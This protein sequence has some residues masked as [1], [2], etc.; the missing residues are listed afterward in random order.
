MNDKNKLTSSAPLFSGMV[1]LFFI[2]GFITILNDLL[3]PV[4]K[5]RLGL[6][7]AESMLVQFCFFFTYFI[8]SLPMAWLVNKL[9]YKKSMIL[10]LM[11]IA[12]GCLVFIPADLELVYGVFLFGLF[13]L[14][15]GVVMLQVSANP[16]VTLLG[17]IDTSSARLTL[18]QGFNSLG[19][20]IAPL[21]VAGLIV[22]SHLYV[23]YIIIALIMVL[24]SIFVSRFN[25]KSVNRPQKHEVHEEAGDFSLW[26]HLTFV[27]GFASIFFYVGA[28]VSAGSLVVNFLHL[29]NIGNLSLLV[30]AR[31]L[32]IYWGGAMVGRLIGVYFLARFNPAKILTLCA[33]ANVILLCSVVVNEGAIAMWSLLLL[34]IFNSI[35]FP[36]IFALAISKLPNRAMKNK[37]G[38]FL[39]MAIVGGAIIPELQG[40][41]ADKI[42]LQNSF[43]LLFISYLVIMGYA[44]YVSM[45]SRQLKQEVISCAHVDTS[46]SAQ[47]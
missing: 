45:A 36:T 22:S 4:L 16:L 37:A 10:G 11:I 46:A 8:M 40:I 6:S 18:A 15:T 17:D 5:A 19:C 35:M 1:V 32:S 26:K 20:V 3:I 24:V 28:E 31:Y 12:L 47:S 21:L 7:Y 44:V 14:A 41:L 13:I 9:N 38:G 39:I 29:P 27:L 2:W 33:I 34:G 30:A 43:V 42:G 25:F 23:P